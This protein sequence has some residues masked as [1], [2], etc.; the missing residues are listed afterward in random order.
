MKAR[1][2][3]GGE[4]SGEVLRLDE[5]LSFWGTFDPREGRIIDVHHPQYGAI[6]TGKILLMPET[7]GSGTA[8]GAI[9][10]AIR[11]GTGPLAILLGIG[12]INLAIGA[13]VAETL[14]GKNCP[15]LEVDYESLKQAGHI[16]IRADGT[17][18]PRGLPDR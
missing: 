6:V 8:P 10:E 12:D 1:V 16:T 13:Q 17:I 11:R 15:V 14:Y 7:R 2:L 4:V 5:P 3:H 9:A 18:T